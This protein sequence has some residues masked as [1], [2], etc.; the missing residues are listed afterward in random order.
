MNGWDR[1]QV[2]RMRA[3]VR[4]PGEASLAASRAADKRLAATDQSRLAS[5][6]PE[7]AVADHHD[8]ERRRAPKAQ[9]VVGRLDQ[10]LVA[11]VEAG[12]EQHWHAGGGM[13]TA[14]QLV[15]ERI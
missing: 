3:P 9:R 1:G 15:E 13:E 11:A 5:S 2:D 10:R 6:A 4:G 8:V 7:H 14:D 12:I